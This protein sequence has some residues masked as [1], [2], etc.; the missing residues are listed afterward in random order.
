MSAAAC[1]RGLARLLVAL[2]LGGCAMVKVQSRGPADYI[3]LTRD[4]LLSTGKLSVASREALQV[5]GVE[6]D[7][8]LK[9]VPACS[10]QLDGMEG[11]DEERRLSTQAELWTAHALA[12]A[13]ARGGGQQD[14]IVDAW[15][16]TARHAYAYLFFTGRSSG[17]RAFETRQGQVRDYYNYAVL[18]VVSDLYARHQGTPVDTLAT[19]ESGPWRLHTD[20]AGYRL[21]GGGNRL[22]ALVAAP[23]LRFDGLRSTYWRDGFGAELVAEVP[24][25]ALGDPAA[26]AT[27]AAP[28]GPPLRREGPDFSEVPFAPATL[29]LQFDGSTQQQVLA[30]REVQ[31]QP[32]DPYR[33]DAVTL[34]GQRVP[35]AANFTAPYGLWLAESGFASQSL[36]SMLGREHGI[37]R[38]H[39][40]LMQPFDPQ[41]RIILMLHGLASSPEAWVN[42]ANEI[43]GDEV[44]RQ[45]Y[46]IWQVYYPTN[47]PIAWNREQIQDLVERTL[48]HFDPS[49]NAPASSRMVLVGH[50]MGGVIGRLLV[51]SS[52]DA[53]WDRFMADRRPGSAE[54][55]RLQ[56]LLRF[57]PLPQVDRAVFIAAP[58]RGTPMA[59]GW[60]GRLVGRLVRLPLT[61]LEGFGDAL[62]DLAGG[63][64]EDGKPPTLPTSIDNLRD[65]DPFIRAAADLPLSP[66]VRYNTI[67]ARRDP[68]V[69]LAE[70][71]DGLV[72]YASAH[73]PGAESEKVITSWHSVQETPQAI[74]EIRRILH[75][76]L[77]ATGQDGTAQ[78]GTAP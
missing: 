50:S 30:T 74:L 63:R 38:P 56:P 42:V 29:L 67:I 70:S 47:M 61:V 16:E 71:N 4:D 36:R 65:T 2:A 51:S 11:L 33:H 62:Q 57:Q 76:E 75:E 43:M 39:L 19:L 15:L 26:L 22:K 3:A 77:A 66:R 46:Q 18:E 49:G 73:M 1:R 64:Q 6:P 35:L 25:D 31:V 23:S 59:G 28:A 14:A 5:A 69:A 13:G 41:R 20:M 10:R 45:H 53:L 40:Y 44:L 78:D 34:H 21:P 32:F 54:R 9:E 37:D 60:L 12:L 24:A 48:R 17:E 8:C 7:P 52:G 68:K 55:A 27:Q 58:Q 72:P